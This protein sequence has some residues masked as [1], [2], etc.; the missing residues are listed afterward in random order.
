MRPRRSSEASPVRGGRRV[1]ADD[2]VGEPG[3]DELQVG[4]RVGPLTHQIRPE[5]VQAFCQ[6]MPFDPAQ[7][8]ERATYERAIMPPTMLATDYVPLLH[9]QLSLGW[10][11]MARH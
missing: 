10:G 8:T 9:R 7:Y 5:M 4:L 3:W 6:A 11:L 2:Y 1:S